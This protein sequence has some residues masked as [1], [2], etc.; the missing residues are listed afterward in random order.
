MKKLLLTGLACALLIGCS[1]PAALNFTP[2]D[3]EPAP[4]SQKINAEIKSINISFATKQE[5]KGELQVG[6]FGNQYEQSF[7][8]TFKSALDEALVRTA[9]FSDDSSNKL[10]LSAK[11]LKFQSP[12]SGI[13]FDTYMT[14]K[15][16]FVNRKTGSSQYI[17]EID[18]FGSVPFDY[19]FMGAIRATEARNRAVKS[20]IEKLLEELK[21][22]KFIR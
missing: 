22:N 19:A 4:Q 21:N 14:V 20:N 3:L 10:S 2:D 11:V 1:A 13:N 17:T 9:L 8:E 16:D 7:K 5:Q 18:S 6:I 15:Y 12:G